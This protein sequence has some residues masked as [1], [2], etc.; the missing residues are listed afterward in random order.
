MTDFNEIKLIIK[1]IF[2][3]KQTLKYNVP[4]TLNTCKITC[5]KSVNILLGQ[6][7]SHS[8][9]HIKNVRYSVTCAG[10]L[11]F[12]PLFMAGYSVSLQEIS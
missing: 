10:D 1:F 9:S 12:L 7:V 3:S 2:C 11:T 4:F 6:P 8:D 5:Q